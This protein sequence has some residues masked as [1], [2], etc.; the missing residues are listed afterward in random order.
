MDFAV[1]KISEGVD[2]KFLR[3]GVY[4][5]TIQ[6]SLRWTQILGEY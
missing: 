4:L 1:G 2:I 3:V 5:T 6:A